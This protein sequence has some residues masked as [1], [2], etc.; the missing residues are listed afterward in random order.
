MGNVIQPYIVLLFLLFNG[1]TYAQVSY[2]DDIQP[3]F[4]ENCTSCHGGLS[5]VTLS[6]YDAVMNGVGDQYNKNIV[7]PGEPDESPIVDKISPNPT[8]GDRM[9]QG[10]PFLD[11]EEINRIRQW[12]TEGALETPATHVADNGEVP[13][14]FELLGNYPNPFNPSTNIRFQLPRPAS[15]SVTVYTISGQYVTEE[16]GWSQAGEVTVTVNLDS[17]SSGMYHY[18]VELRSEERTRGRLTGMMTLVK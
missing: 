17:K 5:G 10:G 15:W 18:V 2:N 14:H 9:P 4:N 12:I 3:I 13:D 1:L 7:I 8:V 11:D 6:S 16:S